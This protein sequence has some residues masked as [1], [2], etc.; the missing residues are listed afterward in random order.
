MKTI[1]VA[2]EDMPL[3][4]DYPGRLVPVRL[5]EV[6][7]R[8]SGIVLERQFEQGSDVHKGDVLFEIDPAKFAAA[9]ASAKAQLSRAEA[10]LSL[11]NQRADRV[12]R[13][14]A[15]NVASTEQHDVALAD[16]KQA[17]AE[18]AVAK[19]NLQTAELELSYASVRSPI[20]GHIGAALV[21]EGALVRQE[22][23]TQMAIVR[24]ISSLY[25]DFIAPLA[26]LSRVR[27]EID[28]GDMQPVESS[29]AIELILVDGST[30]EHPGRLLFSSAVVDETTGQ[31]LLRAEFENPQG[32]L[33]P[34]TYVRVRV[35]EGVAHQAV[36]VPQRAVQWDTLGQASV[37]TVRDGKAAAQPILTSR[38]VGNR[39]LVTQG[40]KSGDQVIVDGLDRAMPGQPVSAAPAEAAAEKAAERG[41]VSDCSAAEPCD[42]P[43]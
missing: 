41:T 24:D 23:G 36:L 7:A 38:S 3:K 8:V 25:V 31:V 21:S 32:K 10:A 30:Y 34:G 37:M 14:L 17:Q 26:E 28:S 9:V 11:A 29:N 6:R 39:W 4:K 42:I 22:D 12:K 15:R 35:T 16:R 27:R 1:T 40:L 13:L 18:V 33:L 2:G 5:A 20:D 43:S 19:A